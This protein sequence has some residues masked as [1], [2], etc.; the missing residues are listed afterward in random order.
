MALP[1]FVRVAT[2][3]VFV[4][5]GGLSVL[6]CLAAPPPGGGGAGRLDA[7]IPLLM[8]GEMAA[9][10]WF[11]ALP[12]R[13]GGQAALFAAATGWFLVR[14]LP[15]RPSALVV[16]DSRPPPPSPAGPARLAY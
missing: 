12:D 2:A 13:W 1:Q 15:P 11:G 7:L 10:A 6:H 14:A 8:S 3:L 9:M 5:T 16:R 4:L